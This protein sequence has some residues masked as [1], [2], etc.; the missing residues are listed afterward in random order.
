MDFNSQVISLPSSVVETRDLTIEMWFRTQ[1]S[2]EQ[3]LFDTGVAGNR[4]LALS[5]NGS[6]QFINVWREPTS[7]SVTRNFATGKPIADLLWH[8][9]ALVRN[10]TTGE[11]RVY[12]DGQELVG[13]GP[14]LTA[15]NLSVGGP[16]VL[17]V[18][19]NSVGSGYNGMF[20]GQ[21][22]EVRFWNTQRTQTEI[23]DN[24][25]LRLSGNDLGLI[26]YYTFDSGTAHD[27]ARQN[28]FQDGTLGD[29]TS[30]G[31]LP[32]PIFETAF[33]PNISGAG[34]TTQVSG[35]QLIITPR[36]GFFG[37]ANFSQDVGFFAFQCHCWI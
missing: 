37:P 8:H 27:I 7:T 5:I 33:V 2:G 23:N 15:G 19:Q 29:Q 36:A 6:Q 24:M 21:M 26:A 12:L 20:T 10:S 17:G 34:L 30:P 32:S 31:T 25:S 11:V 22:D 1:S 16:V 3:F 35:D 9:V 18:A 4:A 14:T 13:S 28:G